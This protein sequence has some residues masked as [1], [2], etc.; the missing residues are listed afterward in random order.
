MGKVYKPPVHPRSVHR[1]ENAVR[2]HAMRGSAPRALELE[3]PRLER[4]AVL[5]G[6]G[7]APNRPRAGLGFRVYKPKVSRVN[8]EKLKM[9]YD[10][11]VNYARAPTGV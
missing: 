3:I 2:G 11:V 8:R 4:G 6:A 10:D 5:T 1:G 7:K 9:L